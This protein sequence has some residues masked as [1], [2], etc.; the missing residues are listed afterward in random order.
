MECERQLAYLVQVINILFSDGMPST[1]EQFD[2][3]MNDRDDDM[4]EANEKGWDYLDFKIAEQIIKL[5]R[6][7]TGFAQAYKCV[8]D[9]GLECSLLDFILVYKEKVI[10]D[11]LAFFLA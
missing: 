10:T 4:E 11:N 2:R 1:K 5:C 9:V 8:R 3:D 7:T 6:H